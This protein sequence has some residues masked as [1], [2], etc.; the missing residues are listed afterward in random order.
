MVTGNGRGGL[1]WSRHSSG[2]QAGDILPGKRLTRKRDALTPYHGFVTRV[3]FDRAGGT[4][5]KPVIRSKAASTAR[6][7]VPRS[8]VGTPGPLVFCVGSDGTCRKP[9]RGRRADLAAQCSAR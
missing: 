6:L 5:Y 9:T 3:F 4:G 1:S 7:S 2:H 8:I